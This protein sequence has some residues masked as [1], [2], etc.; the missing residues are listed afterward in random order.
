MQ[1]MII[2]GSHCLISGGLQ[3]RPFIEALVAN[4]FRKLAMHEMIDLISPII[5]ANIISRCE[6]KVKSEM[7]IVD[8]GLVWIWEQSNRMEGCPIVFSRAFIL[9]GNKSTIR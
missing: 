7:E 4:S 5:F 6:V 3:A 1:A 8:A 2:V 9:P